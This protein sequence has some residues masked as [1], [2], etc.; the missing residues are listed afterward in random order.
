MSRRIVLSTPE[1]VAGLQS[2]AVVLVDVNADL[3]PDPAFRRHQ[4]HRFLS[5]LH[6][7]MSRAQHGLMLV[8]SRESD[9]LTRYLRMQVRDGL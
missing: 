6:L 5:E 1:Y 8:A 2:N 9:G 3:V 4:E 7:G